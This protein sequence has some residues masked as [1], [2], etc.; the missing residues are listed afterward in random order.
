MHVGLSPLHYLKR[1]TIIESG[2]C[3][4]HTHKTCTFCN[5]SKVHAYDN[6]QQ[7][8][9]KFCTILV[10]LEKPMAAH[11]I[12]EPVTFAVRLKTIVSASLL[13]LQATMKAQ[14][15]TLQWCG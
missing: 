4:S 3:T 11:T 8:D 12:V 7:Q 1:D 5:Y 13:S 6:I 10:S 14:S 2:F 15:G 9:F